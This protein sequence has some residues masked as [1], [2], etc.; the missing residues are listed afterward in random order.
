MQQW[1]RSRARD[2]GLPRP[3][4]VSLVSA[5]TGGGVPALLSLLH[6]LVGSRG[7]VWVVRLPGPP[8]ALLCVV[9]LFLLVRADE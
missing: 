5:K 4:A 8:P 3:E 6:R 7:D 9:P 2:A 1:V